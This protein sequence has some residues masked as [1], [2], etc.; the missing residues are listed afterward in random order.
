[1]IFFDKKYKLALKILLLISVKS[2]SSPYRGKDLAEACG[3]SLRSCENIA[4][5]LKKAKIIKGLRGVNG[6]FILAKERRKISLLDVYGAISEDENEKKQNEITIYDEILN[7][8]E[9]NIFKANA[10]AMSDINLED[11]ENLLDENLKISKDDK[12]NFVI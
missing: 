10:E 12:S 11:I 9:D 1:M 7:S 5:N 3:I 6:G 4:Q 2:K 8:I